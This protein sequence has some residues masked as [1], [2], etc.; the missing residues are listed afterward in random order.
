MS[1]DS[2]DRQA[3]DLLPSG[4]DP[5]ESMRILTDYLRNLEVAYN[6]LVKKSVLSQR[7]IEASLRVAVK[8]SEDLEQEKDRL[9]KDLILLSSQVEELESLLSTSNQKMDN[10]EKQSKKLHRE[11]YYL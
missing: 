4:F 3:S 2:I 11:N 8:S 5:L 6:E 10:Y 7:Q 1:D 9:T